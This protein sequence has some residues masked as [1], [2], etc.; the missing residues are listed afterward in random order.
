MKFV[1][2]LTFL[3][4]IAPSYC[5]D[6]KD[7]IG[8]RYVSTESSFTA[9]QDKCQANDICYYVLYDDI[10]DKCL[11]LDCSTNMYI[12]AGYSEHTKFPVK[13]D[14]YYCPTSIIKAIP[15][16]TSNCTY[17]AD[18]AKNEGSYAQGS[19]TVRAVAAV[20][21]VVGCLLLA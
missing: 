5:I 16:P 19:A 1:L 12:M 13:G 8:I 2:P 4:L 11:Q 15:K 20:A 17:L 10:C 6:N 21:A 9:C 7:I 14:A 3:A 18:T